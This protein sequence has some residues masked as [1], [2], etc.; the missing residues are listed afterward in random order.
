[1][2]VVKTLYS[3]TAACKAFEPPQNLEYIENASMK[4]KNSIEIIFHCMIYFNF[5][6]IR[7]YFMQI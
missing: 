1:M 4:E 5:Y 7:I 2:T 3:I 6:S